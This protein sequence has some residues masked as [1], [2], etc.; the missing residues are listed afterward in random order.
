MTLS[1]ADKLR[2]MYTRF[3][4]N[5]DWSAGSEVLAPEIEWHGFD[6]IGLGG[7]YHGLSGVGRFFRE[8]L[9]VKAIRQRMFPS[10]AEARRAAEAVL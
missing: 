1:N 6:E 7:V 8:W 2:D 3:W 10:E 4:D 5:R 9:E